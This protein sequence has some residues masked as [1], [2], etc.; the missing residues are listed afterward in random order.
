MIFKI[1]VYSGV[2]FGMDCRAKRSAEHRI[3]GKLSPRFPLSLLC[4]RHHHHP[5]RD[6]GLFLFRSAG[7]CDSC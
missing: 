7:I 1:S 3:Q 4:V 5:L 6:R 2:S